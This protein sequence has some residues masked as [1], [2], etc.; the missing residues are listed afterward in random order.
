MSYIILL[1]CL[2]IITAECSFTFHNSTDTY[3]GPV[4]NC[5]PTLNGLW[6][7]L[8]DNYTGTAQVKTVKGNFRNMTYY[9][10]SNIFFLDENCVEYL[11]SGGFEIAL[12]LQDQ[13]AKALFVADESLDPGRVF[14]FDKDPGALRIPVASLGRVVWKEFLGSIKKNESL[15]ISFFM[16]NSIW[17]DV[18]LPIF[19]NHLIWL[20]V[21][22]I[23]LVLSSTKLVQFIQENPESTLAL[24]CLASN[25][26]GDT[27][28]LFQAIIDPYFFY[29]FNVYGLTFLIPSWINSL[30]LITTLLLVCYWAETLMPLSSKVKNFL[31]F[32]IW[33]FIIG[34]ILFAAYQT[35]VAFFILV[36]R[37]DYQLVGIFF[38][39]VVSLLLSILFFFVGFK[40]IAAIPADNRKWMNMAIKIII[41]GL[42]LFL[43]SITAFFI[44]STNA[45]NKWDDPGF[46]MFMI[47]A[48]YFELLILSVAYS[49]FF[50]PRGLGSSSRSKTD[51]A[52]SRTNN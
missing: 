13:G 49:L 36:F 40:V 27:L 29:P 35:V 37:L 8:K 28:R 22:G 24:V 41:A 1:F 10:V 5:Y 25:V 20:V 44:G 52:A 9:N 50:Q 15:T 3:N 45:L 16:D 14:L 18:Y 38:A 4:V 31:S 23:P 12:E 46:T 7:E 2:L 42:M 32:L 11:Y 48:R 33:P 21:S 47:N 17:F 51:R 43:G 26:I 30:L 34:S 6:G 39:I 19:F